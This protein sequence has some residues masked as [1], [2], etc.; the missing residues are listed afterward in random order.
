MILE[1]GTNCFDTMAGKV[2]GLFI[3]PVKYYYDKLP[4]CNKLNIAI[5]D[6]EGELDVYYVTLE[7]I[8]RL[9]LPLWARGCCSV[10][11]PHPTLLSIG[12]K[13]EDFKVDTVPVRRI[14]SV[15]DEQGITELDFLK[16]D[17]EGHDQVILRDFFKT[18]KWLPKKIQF[19]DNVLSDRGE[20]ESMIKRLTKKGYKCVK[21]KFDVV[22]VL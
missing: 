11:E 4:E 12:V 2:D 21:Q 8:N 5:S 17:S 10:N 22:C 1:I 18:V 20:V 14:K 7:D 15:L 3:E 9:G 6:V 19:E 16:V 13:L